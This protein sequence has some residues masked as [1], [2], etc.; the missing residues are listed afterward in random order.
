MYTDRV[1]DVPHFTPVT[2]PQ[3]PIPPVSGNATQVPQPVLTA[4]YNKVNIKKSTKDNLQPLL[5][6]L[7]QKHRFALKYH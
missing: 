6:H 5:L 3:Q 7:I 1:G 2:A 4:A